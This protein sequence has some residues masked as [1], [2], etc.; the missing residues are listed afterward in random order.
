MSL[1]SGSWALSKPG[2]AGHGR[3]RKRSIAEAK[4]PEKRQRKCR[5]GKKRFKE[6]SRNSDQRPNRK[7]RKN[8]PP[9]RKQ[10]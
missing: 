2:N 7:E 9:V 5:A 1:R 3:A 6:T 4:K 8:L 10:G